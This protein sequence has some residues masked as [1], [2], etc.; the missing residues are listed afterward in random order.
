MWVGGIPPP[1]VL[2]VF[3]DRVLVCGCWLVGEGIPPPTVL[4]VFEDSRVLVV[5]GGGSVILP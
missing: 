1:T 4:W 5:I 2:W 3:E